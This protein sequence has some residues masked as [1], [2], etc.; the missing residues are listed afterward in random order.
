MI[1]ISRDTE[2]FCTKTEII[3]RKTETVS[4]EMKNATRDTADI[5][6]KMAPVFALFRACSPQ[7]FQVFRMNNIGISD[8]ISPLA[9]SRKSS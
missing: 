3:S 4:R 8:R 1:F 2:K 5:S 9:E 6:R 7:S